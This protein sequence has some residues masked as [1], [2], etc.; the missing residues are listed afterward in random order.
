VVP[1]IAALSL[2]IWLYLLLARGG[3][4][5][6]ASDSAGATP[7]LNLTRRVVA[8]IPAR[9]EAAVIG[10]AVGSLL[11]QSYGGLLHVIVVDD[12]STDGTASAALEAA[13][14]IGAAA[15]LTVVAGVPL[16]PGWT[17]KLWAMSQGVA[18][19]VALEPDF[20]LL[21]DADIYH[22]ATNVESLVANAETHRRDL[23]SYMVELRVATLAEKL[24]IP[25]FVFFFFQLY[26]PKW[27]ASPHATTA[28]AAG[29]C[30]LLR[31]KMLARIGGLEAIRSQ[32]IDDCALARAT[33][34]A[35]GSVWLQTTRTARSLRPYGSFA[36]I[37]R[38]ISRSAFNQLRHS[39]LLLAATVLALSVTYM[40]PPLLLFADR[41]LP[42][43]LAAAS[44][45]L[46]SGCYAPMV[47]F[48]R[49]S[50]LWSLCLP[51]IA[52]FYAAATVHSALQY[53]LRRGGAWKGRIQDLRT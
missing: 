44:W 15:R 38:M 12:G 49:L 32:L 19:A 24:L 10:K 50:P 17:G 39:Y 23:V 3:F 43:A 52:L 11:Q 9:D 4:W 25:A 20:L 1:T 16:R 37:G 8:I 26:P 53:S 22:Q 35:G 2:L 21:T 45:A 5:R 31:R 41:P 34:A 6:V 27:I 46:M 42:M 30:M 7:A 51:A 29:G 18:A 36:E 33:K 14:R 13:E 48:Y 28:A 40:L 47:R